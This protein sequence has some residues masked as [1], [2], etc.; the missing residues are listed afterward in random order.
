MAYIVVLMLE[1]YQS[2]WFGAY[3]LLGIIITTCV[4]VALDT[5]PSVEDLFEHM[6]MC[7]RTDVML[8]KESLL[9]LKVVVTIFVI[10]VVAICIGILNIWF[11]SNVGITKM[12]T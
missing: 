12:W 1:L 3:S 9:S 2:L 10:V 4:N 8:N 7:D 6:N 11:S 5:R